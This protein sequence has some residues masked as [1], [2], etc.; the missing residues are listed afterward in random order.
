MRRTALL[1]VLAIVAISVAALT[2]ACESSRPVMSSTLSWEAPCVAE[3]ECATVDAPLDYDQPFGETITLALIRH[4]AKNPGTRVGSLFVN[5]GGPGIGGISVLPV[6]LSPKNKLFPTDLVERFDIVSWD[7][8]GVGGSRP[9]Q[10]FD[11]KQEEEDFLKRLPEGFPVSPM[12]KETWI[13]VW[14]DFATRC[15]KRV[16]KKL[17]AHISTTDSALD[18]ELLRR[19]VRDPQL[20]YIGLSYGT[21]IGATYA[22]LFPDKVRALVLDGNLDPVKWFK[23][24]SGQPPLSTF[25]RTKSDIAAGETLARFLDLCSAAATARCTFSAGDPKATHAKFDKLLT[26]LRAAPVTIGGPKGQ[27]VRY[28]YAS[29]V[30]I[31]AYMIYTIQPIVGKSDLPGWKAGA[32]LMQDLWMASEPAAAAASASAPTAPPPP[33][34]RGNQSYTSYTQQYAVQCPESPN[35]HQTDRYSQIADFAVTRSGPIGA[36]WAWSDEPCANWPTRAAHV[37]TGPWNPRNS[38][39]ILV[40]GNTFDPSTRYQGSLDMVSRLANARL[41]TLDGY[42]HTAVLNPSR[43]VN[44]YE[45]AYLLTGDLPPPNTHCKQSVTPFTD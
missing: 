9:V 29:A 45:V 37:Y 19:A 32:Q 21:L 14:D 34:P 5:P 7:P 18:L 30:S 39:P 15:D 44:E 31:F 6:L 16:G 40:I 23:E 38:A 26:R 42:G 25:I 4:R 20:S 8:R 17:L 27:T 12:E 2:V 13:G 3:F 22:N 10:C 11:T 28:T 1:A 41:L 35:P 43:C 24:P 36:Y 33:T